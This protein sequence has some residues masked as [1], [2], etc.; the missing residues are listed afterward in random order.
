MGTYIGSG[1]LMEDCNICGVQVMYIK[2]DIP[3]SNV[4]VKKQAVTLCR[5]CFDKLGGKTI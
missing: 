4:E 1:Y 3:M 2:Q 5:D